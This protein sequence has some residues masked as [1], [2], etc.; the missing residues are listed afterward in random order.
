MAALSPNVRVLGVPHLL[1]FS[2]LSFSLFFPPLFL[3]AALL[4]YAFAL[5]SVSLPEHSIE[6]WALKEASSL[7]AVC[8]GFPFQ[9]H[10]KPWPAH[11][12]TTV[13][14]PLAPLLAT[15]S[16][17]PNDAPDFRTQTHAQPAHLPQADT[18]RTFG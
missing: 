5:Y 12:Y 15:T 17:H 9:R 1:C 7:S 16:S 8:S 3:P 2:F 13:P 14:F 10:L 11:S 6:T 4:R 18:A